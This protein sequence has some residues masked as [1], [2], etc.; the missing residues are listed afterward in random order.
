M[1]NNQKDN[2]TPEDNVAL[3]RMAIDR[4]FTILNATQTVVKDGTPI[5][6]PD[7]SARNEAARIFQK[8]LHPWY[9]K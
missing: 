1:K 3:R 4:L 6:E 8:L 2:E 9:G 5:T 7:Y